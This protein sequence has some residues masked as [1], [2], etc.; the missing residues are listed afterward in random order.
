MASVPEDT[1]DR[2]AATDDTAAKSSARKTA[3]M[4]AG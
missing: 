4:P 2:N 3:D 1:L